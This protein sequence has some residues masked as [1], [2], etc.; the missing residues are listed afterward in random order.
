MFPVTGAPGHLPAFGGQL[1]HPAS[2][3]SQ[4]LTVTQHHD[5]LFLVSS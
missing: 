4:E 1:G 5:F 2:K 3:G